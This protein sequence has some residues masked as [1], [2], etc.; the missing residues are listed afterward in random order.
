MYQMINDVL[1]QNSLSQK[2]TLDCIRLLCKLLNYTGYNYSLMFHI[3]K[4]VIAY[5]NPRV[6]SV[7]K[8][9]VFW[10]CLGKLLVRRGNWL[11]WFCKISSL[12]HSSLLKIDS[13]KQREKNSTQKCPWLRFKSDMWIVLEDQLWILCNIFRKNRNFCILIQWLITCVLNNNDKT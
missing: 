9:I 3:L 13:G 1:Y 8:R 10:W 11:L 4:H 2:I 12:D 6:N 7:S 5:F